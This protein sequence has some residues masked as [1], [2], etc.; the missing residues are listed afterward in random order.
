MLA[1]AGAA[2]FWG[3]PDASQR[4]V[5]FNRH[6]S[7][8]FNS[9]CMS[10]HGGVKQHSTVSFSYRDQALGKGKSARPVIAPGNPRASEL[11]ARITSSDPEF[12]MP[13]HGVPLPQAQITLLRQWIKE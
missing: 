9:Q 7:Q 8:F 10:S 2:A 6:I 1:A 11:M 4:R 13:L 5:D 3:R 12:R